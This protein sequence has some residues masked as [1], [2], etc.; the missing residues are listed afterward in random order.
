M[1][2]FIIFGATG[3]LA[4]RK[5][6]PALYSL[7]RH[8]LLA[9]TQI[10]GVSRS[11]DLGDAGFR[12][13]VRDSAEAPPEWC[14]TCVHYRSIGEGGVDDFQ[15]LAAEIHSIERQFSLSGNR[16]FY[17]ALPPDAF[18]PTIEG[19]GNAGLNQSPGWIRLVI[20]KPFGRDLA[21]A[22][23]LNELTRRFFA[24]SQIYRID[25][26]LGKETVQNLL[27]FRFTNPIFESLWN[28]TQID[29]VQITV[30]ED[31][32][33]ENRASYYDQTGALRDMVQNHLTQILSLIGMEVPGSLDAESVRDEKV[34]VLR[35][36]APIRRQHVVFGQY[37]GYLE[38]KGVARNSRTETFVAMKLEVANWR[39]NGVP[40]YLRTGKRMARR[41][42]QVAIVFKCAPV[43][44]FR[45][46]GPSCDLRSNVLIVVIQPD[47]GFQLQFEIKAPGQPLSITAQDLQ[48][49]YADV[50]KDIPDGYETLLEEVLGGEQALFV[51][52]DWVENSWRFFDDI[53]DAPI[54]VNPYPPGSWGPK[55][56]DALVK[57]VI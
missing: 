17:L 38:E 5:L 57:W 2:L 14:D 13:L 22:Q 21:S 9:G 23:Q 15:R 41:L 51:R 28:R 20:E 33:V 31:L 4:R 40:F 42:S 50:F 25:H 1:C 47:E 53:L 7:A 27:V 46:F 52:S 48:F 32:G 10:L 36:L 35:S 45:P 19:I 44:I 18:S 26:Y 24:E 11:R 30:A 6:I 56:A 43:S 16:V 29:H 55:E 3:D 8:G 12:K 49:R 34:K 39:W 37:E 54:Q